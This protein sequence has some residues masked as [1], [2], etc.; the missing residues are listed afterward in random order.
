MGSVVSHSPGGGF[1][2]CTQRPAEI[3][4]MQVFGIGMFSHQKKEKHETLSSVN[5]DIP[6]GKL[7]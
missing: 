4:L 2:G 5:W 1:R 7:T 3:S 6:S